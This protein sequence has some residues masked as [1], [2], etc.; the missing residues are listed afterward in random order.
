MFV[1]EY[2]NEVK[3]MWACGK[4]VTLQRGCIV[5]GF[6]FQLRGPLAGEHSHPASPSVGFLKEVFFSLFLKI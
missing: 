1:S 5:A 2:L 3:A 4:Q 6:G